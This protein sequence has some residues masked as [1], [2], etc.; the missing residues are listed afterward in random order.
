MEYKNGGGKMSHDWRKRNDYDAEQ[1]IFF[2]K[3]ECHLCEKVKAGRYMPGRFLLWI[4]NDCMQCSPCYKPGK[5]KK[6]VIIE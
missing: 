1:A 3:R 2:V 6:Q 4:C 5:K